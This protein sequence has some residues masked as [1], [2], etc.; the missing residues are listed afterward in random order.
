MTDK[1]D[2]MRGDFDPSEAIMRA[3]QSCEAADKAA[4][5]KGYQAAMQSPAVRELVSL[6]ESIREDCRRGAHELGMSA[7]G[8]SAIAARCDKALAN[9]AAI[10]KGE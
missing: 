10:A 9:F 3:K 7:A 2:V 5:D 8:V 1:T 6:A 4:Y